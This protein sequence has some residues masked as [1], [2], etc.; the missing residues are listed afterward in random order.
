MNLACG[1]LPWNKA[2]LSDPHFSTYVFRDRDYIYNNFPISLEVNN[3]LK[4]I[5]TTDV[6]TRISIAGLRKMIKIVPSF[7]N[8]GRQMRP[9]MFFSERYITDDGIFDSDSSGS[10]AYTFGSEEFPHPNRCAPRN[11]VPQQARPERLSTLVNAPEFAARHSMRST[12]TLS[13]AVIDRLID[14]AFTGEPEEAA[15]TRT[16]T[17]EMRRLR[18]SDEEESDITEANGVD[19]DE[20]VATGSQDL[21]EASNIGLAPDDGQDADDDDADVLV[22]PETR[23]ADAPGVAGSDG[24]PLEEVPDLDTL[25]NDLSTNGGPLYSLK[26]IVQRVTVGG[27]GKAKEI[28]SDVTDDLPIPSGPEPKRIIRNA[29]RMMRNPLWKTKVA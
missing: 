14:E 21:A 25:D 3:I 29:A 7:T 9:T 13:S 4:C 10:T 18:V 8:P 24:A 28:S 5:F 20:Q 23:A 6:R 17:G 22:T 1:C 19:E 26:A 11:S 16:M 15:L 2:S 12:D 27:K